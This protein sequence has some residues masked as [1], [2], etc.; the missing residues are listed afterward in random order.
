MI[1]TRQH[2]RKELAVLGFGFLLFSCK[3][4]AQVQA[5]P[6]PV[7]TVAKPVVKEVVDWL[8]FTAQT[9]AVISVD[10][11]PRVSGYIDKITFPEGGIVDQGMLLFVIDP[12]PYQAA[13]DQAQGQLEQAQAQQKL[14][15]ANLAR[16]EELFLSQLQL[17]SY[18]AYHA[19]PTDSK[20][21][22]TF[23]RAMQ[24]NN[25]QSLGSLSSVN[26]R[27]R[28]GCLGARFF[29]TPRSS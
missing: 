27:G 21:M 5:P 17:S 10:I 26:L 15:V 8:Y 29:F 3:P 23:R 6:P 19:V 13:L 9:Q 25:S 18:F 2:F 11:R 12:R 1:R 24:D 16:A 20:A 22:N 14:N 4:S 7:V 28:A